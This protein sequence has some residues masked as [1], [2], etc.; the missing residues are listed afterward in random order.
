ML[1]LVEHRGRV[2]VVVDGPVDA[3][4]RW[5]LGIS[6]AA[7]YLR[8]VDG[9]ALINRAD[10]DR[11]QSNFD[12]QR[13]VWQNISMRESERA[14]DNRHVHVAVIAH[15]IA[16]DGKFEIRALAIAH[17]ATKHDDAKR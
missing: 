17:K 7:G 10:V 4:I 14:V 1:G 2:S 5:P 3:P 9:M 13:A 6:S 8:E 15:V 16:V 11:R 12:N